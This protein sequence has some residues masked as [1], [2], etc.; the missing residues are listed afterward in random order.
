[1]NARAAYCVRIM[2]PKLGHMS[3]SDIS[4]LQGLL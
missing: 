1:M 2:I 4:L 3:E